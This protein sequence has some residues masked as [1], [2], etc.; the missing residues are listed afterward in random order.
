M[1]LADLTDIRCEEIE[2]LAYQGTCPD[3][4][5]I[6]ARVYQKQFSDSCICLDSGDVR[7]ALEDSRRCNLL[8]EVP[9]QS[10]ISRTRSKNYE[11][12]GETEQESIGCLGARLDWIAV[13]IAG[14][15]PD[16]RRTNETQ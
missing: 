13:R 7:S 6:S 5:L 1:L 9:G 14:A 12:I 16:G 2:S 8:P 15:C 4:K 3:T 10:R 11:L